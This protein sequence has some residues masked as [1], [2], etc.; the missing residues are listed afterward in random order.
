LHQNLGRNIGQ[1]AERIGTTFVGADDFAKTEVHNFAA[2]GI[3]F[4]FD[5]NVFWLQIS[6]GDAE[7]M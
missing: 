4:V 5:K 3:T 2:G 1:G 6:V 7:A